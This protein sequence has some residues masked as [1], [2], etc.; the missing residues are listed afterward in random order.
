[1]PM[2]AVTALTREQILRD[3]P[4]VF[5]EQPSGKTSNRYAFVPTTQVIDDL[6]QA[7]WLPVSARESNVR[8]EAK[9]G[10]QKH[11][12]RFRHPELSFDRLLN[13]GDIIPEIVL[14]N[15]HDALS[16]FHLHAGIFRLVCSNGMVVADATIAKV[17]IKH[18]GYASQAAHNAGQVL[19]QNLPQLTKTIAS[20]QAMQLRAPEASLMANHA[21]MTRWPVDDTHTPPFDPNRL[22]TAR[23]TADADLTLWNVFQ[24][25]QENMI[26]GGIHYR[27]KKNVAQRTRKINS[28][29]EEIRVNKALWAFA[30]SIL[31]LKR[32]EAA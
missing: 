9:E 4:S 12:V 27:T 2:I 31:E 3:A 10:Y 22:L 14:T 20:M 25:I 32:H 29:N 17:C 13:V 18:V 26:K 24:R 7:G 11:M 15:S 8:D 21:A 30:E 6:G 28:I 1:M 19:F 5:A 23:R 16:A